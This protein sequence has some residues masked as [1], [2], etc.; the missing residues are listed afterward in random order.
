MK[1]SAKRRRLTERQILAWA[2]AHFRRLGQWPRCHSGPM[3]TVPDQTWRAVDE[4]LRQGRRGLPGGSSLAQLLAQRRRVRNHMR[5]PR[6]TPEHIARWALDHFRRTGQWPTARSGPVLG[7][8]AENWSAITTS[9]YQGQRGLPKGFSLAQLLAQRGYKRSLKH[10]PPLA[11]EQIVH[12]VEAHQQRTGK[13]PTHKAGPVAE[14][15]GETWLG[16]DKALAKGK[17]GLPGGSSIAR[18]VLLYRNVMLRA[19]WEGGLSDGRSPVA[20]PARLVDILIR[21]EGIRGT[22]HATS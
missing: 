19:H 18:L 4:A 14:A 16:V 10:L 22:C 13:W 21:R 8:P 5:L 11:V 9:L 6:L 2:D 7:M 3:L 15:P 17:R 1:G 20:T 12:W